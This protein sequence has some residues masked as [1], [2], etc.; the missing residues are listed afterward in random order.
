MGI[1]SRFR[2]IMASNLNAL[3]DNAEDPEK[4]MDRM[5]RSLNS[6]L[7]N[8]KAEMAAINADESRAKRALDE[9]R[10]E[11]KKLWHY[12]EKSAEAGN[13]EDARR[14]LE[15]KAALAAKEA[16]FQASYDAASQKVSDMLQLHDKLLSD[17]GQLEARYANMKGKLAAAKV[18]QKLHSSD[19]KNAEE[20]I[21]TA[22]DEAMA[23]A[24]LRAGKNDDLDEQI[25]RLKK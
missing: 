22:Y 17:I 7:G 8:V 25:K 24:E 20:K 2:D 10:A 19:F 4:T 9:C 5:M 1:L 14:F 6:D 18:Q 15:R 3:L 12:A 13:E 16:Q 23:L 21:N 11:I